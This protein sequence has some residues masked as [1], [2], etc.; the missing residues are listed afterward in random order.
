MGTAP[1]QVF[2]RPDLALAIAEHSK[3][4]PRAFAA[5]GPLGI[6]AVGVV[7]DDI[8]AML[9]VGV[10]IE[11]IGSIFPHNGNRASMDAAYEALQA[12][13][14]G[15]VSMWVWDYAGVTPFE[16]LRDLKAG[17]PEPVPANQDDLYRGI[18]AA[19][20]E[21]VAAAVEIMRLST[22]GSEGGDLTITDSQA[23]GGIV[24]ALDIIDQQRLLIVDKA[25]QVA[26]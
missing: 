22:P 7:T 13:N 14:V 3:G 16:F 8:N 23:V 4:Q 25:S 5:P 11:K 26:V 15:R 12:F 18:G 9:R 19:A 24:S 2:A 20:H 1:E 17:Q 6:T 21:I 10:P